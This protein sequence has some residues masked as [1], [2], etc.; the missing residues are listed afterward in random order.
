VDEVRAGLRAR[1]VLD[2]FGVRY[3]RSGSELRASQCPQC[4]PHKRESFSVRDRGPW[5]C[6]IGS[7]G[8]DL[9]DL[10]ALFEGINIRTHFGAVL[11]AAAEIAGVPAST[12]D[13]E[14]PSRQQRAAE[15][16]RR[17]LAA[18]RERAAD[19]AAKL[20]AASAIAAPVWA[21][22]AHRS[23]AG[24]AYL[25][26]RGLESIVGRD[27]LVRFDDHG[28]RI[29]LHHWDGR[30]CDVPTR[31]LPGRVPSGGPTTRSI[32][33][34]TTAGAFGGIHQLDDDPADVVIAEGIFDY[35]SAVALWPSRIAI[36][37][38]GAG[39]LPCVAKA[40]ASRVRA[41]Q[42]RVY[43]VPHHD[44]PGLRGVRAAMRALVDAGIDRGRIRVLDVSAA[45]DLNDWLRGQG[46]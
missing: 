45:G 11:A 28:I 22:L 38:H 36:G 44:E 8:G 4:G 21:G 41:G 46:R 20:E 27:D 13:R 35:L 17:Q 40:V 29:A 16:R 1:D 24:E 43:L 37:A 14:I 6:K 15:R 31:L 19:E 25:V 2:R 12:N 23:Q 18:D 33:G 26:D 7:H 42:R 5:H 10:V 3:R 39:R 30:V 9:L 34:C 32:R